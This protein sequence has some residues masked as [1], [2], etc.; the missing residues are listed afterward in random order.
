MEALKVEL[1]GLAKEKD[2]IELEIAERSARLTA[3]GMPGLKGPLVD[4]EGFPFS[5]V[6]VF[7]V[8]QTGTA[9]LVLHTDHKAVSSKIERKLHELHALVKEVKEAGEPA[10]KQP[11]AEEPTPPA[12][13]AEPMNVDLEPFAIIDEVSDA[14]PASEAG[15]EVG[16]QL[17]RFGG[18]VKSDGKELQRIGVNIQGFEG[19]QVIALVARGGQALELTLTP[20][21]W[22]GRGL[23]GCH[24]KPITM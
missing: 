2:T 22:A 17:C 16:D 19:Q 10:L 14:S 24:M 21:K 15:M 4:K 9:W 1:K 6:D 7:Q 23:L 18:I 20:K 11:R 3:P 8:G 12:A 5:H 13:E